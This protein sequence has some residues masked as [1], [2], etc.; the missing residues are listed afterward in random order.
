[1]E[2]KR[3]GEPAGQSIKAGAV[4]Q[5][6]VGFKLEGIVSEEF[7]D[8]ISMR[9]NILDLFIPDDAGLTLEIK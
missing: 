9:Y 5:G 7:P 3:Q 8:A 1:V 4:F 6:S 2:Y